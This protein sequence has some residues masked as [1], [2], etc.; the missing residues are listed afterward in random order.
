ML[1]IFSGLDSSG[2]FGQL[3]HYLMLIFMMGLTAVIFFYFWREKQLDM[4]EQAKY[5]MLKEEDDD[6]PKN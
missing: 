4:D 3:L 2:F 5:Q 1:C 6:K